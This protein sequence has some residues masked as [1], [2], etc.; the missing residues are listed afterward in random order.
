MGESSNGYHRVR[1]A[2][3]AGSWYSDNAK[4]LDRQLSDLL[5]KAG[6]ARA[7]IAPHAGYTY[8]GD[9]AAF[10]FRQIVPDRVKRVFVMDPSHVVFISG[11]GLTSCGKFRTPLGDLYV[12]TRVNNDLLSS[13]A[14]EI[15]NIHN[16]EAEHSIEMRMPFIGK[17]MDVCPVRS[18]TIVPVLVGPLTT[19]RQ[20]QYGKM[21][22][23][24]LEDPQNLFVISSD[25]CHW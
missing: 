14:F 22:A 3:H 6:P 15:T 7:I 23:H 5:E 12:D 1:H 24:Y 19:A 16:E 17:V 4:E 10:A 2:T 11:C 20:I 21:F 13:D 25:F 18:F 9:T 8:C